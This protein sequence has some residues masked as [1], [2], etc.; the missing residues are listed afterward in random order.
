MAKY[1]IKT[2]QITV[3]SVDL[4]EYLEDVT[5]TYEADEIESTS[6]GTTVNDKTFV[7]GLRSWSIDATLQQDYASARV[8]ATLFSLVGADPFA[9]KVRPTSAAKGTSNPEFSGNAILL[10]YPPLTGKVGE[11]ARVTVKFRGTGALTRSTS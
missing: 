7:A 8:D 9:I 1:V 10:S 6:S 4:S 3:N 11:M 2:P 5:L